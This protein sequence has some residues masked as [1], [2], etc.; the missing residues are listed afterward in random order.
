MIFSIG[1]LPRRRGER[2]EGGRQERE[3][4]GGE[5]REKVGESGGDTV[6]RG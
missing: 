2:G 5:K 6:V 4:R 1:N 3:E